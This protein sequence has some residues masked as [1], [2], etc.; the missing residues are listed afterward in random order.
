[1]HRG[2]GK[3]VSRNWKRRSRTSVPNWMSEL[4]I[5]RQNGDEQDNLTVKTSDTR[6]AN[7][8]VDI[9]NAKKY[10]LGGKHVDLNYATKA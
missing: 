1:M 3:A 5:L 8:R 9:V 10:L 4:S 2:G 7:L 6:G